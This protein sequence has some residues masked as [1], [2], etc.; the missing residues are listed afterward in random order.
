MNIFYIFIYLFCFFLP[1]SRINRKQVSTVTIFPPAPSIF[2]H[3]LGASSCQQPKS[4]HFLFSNNQ[5]CRNIR[6]HHVLSAKHRAYSTAAVVGSQKTASALKEVAAV[7]VNIIFSS[8]FIL[9]KRGAVSRGDYFLLTI[10][11]FDGQLSAFLFSLRHNR[12]IRI[13]AQSPPIISCTE[14][15]HNGINKLGLSS[16]SDGPGWECHNDVECGRMGK[17]IELLT[18][19]LAELTGWKHACQCRS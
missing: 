3:G 5:F 15:T 7:E 1:I 4:F 6:L 18:P 2:Y 16:S 12:I 8:S 17:C 13:A 14:P 11:Y 19:G 10:S 9:I